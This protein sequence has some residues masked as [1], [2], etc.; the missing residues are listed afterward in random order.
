M[1]ADKHPEIRS[2]PLSEKFELAVELWDEVL[3]HEAELNEPEGLSTL[4][5][6]RLA[7]YRAGKV[8]GRSWEEVRRSI[9]GA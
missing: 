9:Q 8:Q 2:L 4:L 7:D 3:Q 6:Q 5:E 1:I